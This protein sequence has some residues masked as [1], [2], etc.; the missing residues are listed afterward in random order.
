MQ[1]ALAAVETAARRGLYAVGVVAYGAAPAFDAALLA[2]HDPALPLIAFRLFRATAA[3]RLPR[4]DAP[5]ERTPWEPDISAGAYAAAVRQVRAGLRLGHCYQVNL[6]FRLARPFGGDDDPY[7]SFHRL[8]HAQAGRHA[9]YLDLGEQVLASASPE[10]FFER[11]GER[12][13]TCP[14][15][16]TA[17]R[18]PQPDEDRRA[19][20]ELW[21]S[22]KERAENLMIVDMLRNDL[23]RVAAVGS[24]EVA[25]LFAI[26]PYPTVW[27]MTSTVTARS[28]AS[29]AQLFAALFPCASVTG[30]PKAAA[31][32]AVAQLERS[33]RGFYTG[34][35]GV[36]EPGGDARFGVV[37]RSL[38]F[39]RV[40]GEQTY[41]TG[42]AVVW[43]S[44]P[45]GEYAECAAKAAVL[46]ARIERP[47]LI[48]T[49]GWTPAR[50]YVRRQAHLRRMRR[51]AAVL[52]LPFPAQRL[53]RE[54]DAA[55]RAFPAR[56]RRVRVVL[57]PA[58]R[59]RV[60]HA[61]APAPALRPWRLALAPW[62]FDAADRL[63]YHKT[64]QRA[65]YEHARAACPE[66]DDALLWNSRGE[67]TESTVANVAFRLRGARGWVTPPVSSGLLA[68]VGRAALLARGVLRERVVRVVDLEHCTG[69]R[70]VNSLRGVW[71]A[72]LVGRDA[73][74]AA[75]R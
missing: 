10:L 39:D 50:G 73:R 5:P 22:P 15:K 17:R 38:T 74:M 54:L 7:R 60:D 51:S 2:R 65:L 20:R 11:R 43:D 55:A 9:L 69:V 52:G 33:P 61:P 24:V 12:I 25:R 66:A 26:E 59:V 44:D 4:S 64:T 27:Q 71:P 56:P 29:L 41:G 72:E 31:M 75:G 49:L 13:R 8:A 32:R 47:G 14:M 36:V 35:A 53:R 67:L 19:A 3:L 68:G 34:A 23:G 37:I 40:R 18:R 46:D 6:T 58:G 30:A 48:E 21:R 70:L 63:R 1:D 42:S 45:A 16:G 57:S 28:R 62:P